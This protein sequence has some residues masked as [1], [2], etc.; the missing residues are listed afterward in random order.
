VK[1]IAPFVTL[2]GFTS[3]VPAFAGSMNAASI[4]FAAAALKKSPAG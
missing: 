4:A 2:R 3:V 1:V